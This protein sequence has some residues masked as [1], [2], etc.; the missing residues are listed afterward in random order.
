MVAHSKDRVLALLEA[1]QEKKKKT[2]SSSLHQVWSIQGG[3]LEWV[4][5]K[6]A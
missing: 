5:Y 4:L 3:S 2:Q 6:E 1:E